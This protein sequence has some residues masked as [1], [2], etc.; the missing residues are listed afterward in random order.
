MAEVLPQVLSHRDFLEDSKTPSRAH[1]LIKTITC[2]DVYNHGAT[3]QAYALL[4]YLQNHGHEVEIID[5]KPDYLSRYNLWLIGNKWKRKNIL[6][7][8]IYLSLKFPKRLVARRARTPF[9]LFKKRYMCITKQCYKS[10]DELKKDPPYADAYIVGSDQ[11]WNTLYKNGRDPAFY[12]DFAPQGS[13]RIA[14][15]ASFSLPEV[16]PEYKEFVRS[17][18]QKLDFISVREASGIGILKS[19]GVDR[20]THVLDPVFLLDRQEWE[21]IALG[22]FK[23]KYILVYT[24]GPSP[25]MERIA[26]KIREERHL[27]IYAVQNYAKTPYADTDHYPC[28]PNTFV[29]LIKGAEVVLSNSF[30]ATAFSVIYGRPFYVF[31]RIDEDVNSR[32]FE[33]LAMCGLGERIVRTEEDYRRIKPGWEYEDVNGEIARYVITSK[34]YIEHALNSTLDGNRGSRV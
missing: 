10:C 34:Q 25:V 24:V 20:G 9:E 12:L 6:V 21:N 16:L 3:L 27:K 32:M 2:H 7:R 22:H 11:V 26:M 14:Y 15:A 8:A 33:L 28:G 29:S 23:E 1:M 30:H 13:R 18:I 4:K 17:M 31:P 19:L 5:Y